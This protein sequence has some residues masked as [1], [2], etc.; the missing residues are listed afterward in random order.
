MIW[1]PEIQAQKYET[2]FVQLWDR[3]RADSRKLQILSQFPFQK[4]V[5]GKYE[6]GEP[7]DLD[8]ARYKF[9]SGGQEL[10]WEQWQAFLLDAEKQ[11][12]E[13]AQ[14]EWHHSRFDPPADTSPARSEVNFVLH[15]AREEPAHR[16]IIRGV[17]DITWQP[18][19][20]VTGVPEPAIIAVKEMEL[21]E[22]ERPPAF[23]EVFQVKG[24]EQK[25][26]V[27]PLAVYD[28]D[29]DGLSE[30][31]LGGQ[32]L[33]IRNQGRGKLVAEQ[34]LKH[35]TSIFDAAI[36]ADFTGD[37]PVDFIAVD[38]IG[39]LRLFIGDSNGRFLS[40]GIRVSDDGVFTLPKVFTRGG[41]RCRR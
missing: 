20:I 18:E 3:L 13:I 10:S 2:R 30:I 8:I 1:Q 19:N 12:Y 34:F 38:D 41:Y 21:L 31:V 32:N 35:E 5:L 29:N 9:S 28:L 11:D 17:L 14:T 15:V 7:L 24:N 26:R 6:S 37:G 27:L 36:L 4:L 23:R 39:A 16:I 40:P 22:R 25:P 33:V